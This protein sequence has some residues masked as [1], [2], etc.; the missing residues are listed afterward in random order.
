VDDLSDLSDAFRAVFIV[1]HNALSHD[2][3]HHVAGSITT[4]SALGEHTVGPFLKSLIGYLTS[5]GE[6]DDQAAS[7][8]VGLSGVAAVHDFAQLRRQPLCRV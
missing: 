4:T 7:E 2:W 8:V 5:N 3:M 1:L 6:L